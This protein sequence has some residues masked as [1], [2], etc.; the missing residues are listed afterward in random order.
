M[1]LS[2]DEI[3]MLLGILLGVSE[4]VAL[5]PKMKSN[6][7]LQIVINALK[8]VIGKKEKEPEKS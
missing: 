3:V 7:V 8:R 1:E 5:N 4:L 6:S 2:Q